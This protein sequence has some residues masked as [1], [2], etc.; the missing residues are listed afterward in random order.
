MWQRRGHA[1][2]SLCVLSV[3]LLRSAAPA[4]TAPR[5][6]S[7]SY[8]VEG[9]STRERGQIE[10]A[11]AAS[12]FDWR[13]LPPIQVHVLPGVPARSIPGHVWLSSELLASGRFG[14]AV[15]QDEFAHQVD[16]FLLDDDER[17]LLNAALGGDSWYARSDLPH[18]RRGV[19]R[20]TSTFVWA[21]WP[22]RENSYRPRSRSDESAALGP[23]SFRNLLERVLAT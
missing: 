10:A 22:A 9:G 15:I 1:I 23:R 21:Y 17:A 8:A 18:E 16:F 6:A 4:A 5:L 12:S 14:W 11:L 2:A 20:F 13:L 19:E 3:G 7:A